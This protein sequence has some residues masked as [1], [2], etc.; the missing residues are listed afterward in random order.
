MSSL[1]HKSIY[2][3]NISWRSSW[4]AFLCLLLALFF[5]TVALADTKSI[6]TIV[7]LVNDAEI[8]DELGVTRAAKQ[9][10]KVFIGDEI[11][12]KEGSW[13]TI[14]F[15]DL[16]RIV[17]RPNSKLKLTRF[18][19]TLSQGEIKV[20]I[21]QGGARFTTGTLVSKYPNEFQLITPRGM[22]SSS[23]SEWVVRICN[24][25]DCVNQESQQ[26]QC[27]GLSR[28]AHNDG[29]YITVYKGELNLDKCPL[30]HRIKV[31]ETL[32]QGSDGDRCEVVPVVPCF[33]LFDGKMGRDKVRQYLPLLKTKEADENIQ[34]PQIKETQRGVRNRTVI[35]RP[36]RNRRN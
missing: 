27:A 24:D 30:L 28:L 21:K 6:A 29:Q 34:R 7:R 19:E 20:E 3:L 31:G 13:L 5:S 33:V 17:I 36:A 25:D 12:T 18:P 35:P 23:R 9:R 10:G 16:T 32:M 2:C 14:N 1:I 4:K 15:F 26:N 8:V 22:L 11:Q